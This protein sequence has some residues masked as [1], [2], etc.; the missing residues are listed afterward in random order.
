MVLGHPADVEPELLRGSE[1]AQ[2]AGIH[3]RRLH[4]VDESGEDAET[5]RTPLG[6]SGLPVVVQPVTT[7]GSG[8]VG[9]FIETA[10]SGLDVM[11]TIISVYS[12]LPTEPRSPQCR[13]RREACLAAEH[14]RARDS[15]PRGPPDRARSRR[16]AGR[17]ADV[18]AAIHTAN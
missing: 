9:D 6:R 15:A 2:P 5:E 4:V 14:Y 8:H 7:A 12:A 3:F 18:D 16:S 17:R 1:Q 11:S 13:P 10:T